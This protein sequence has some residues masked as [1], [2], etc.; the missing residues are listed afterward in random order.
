V[1]YPKRYL[2]PL[3]GS[4]EFSLKYR[5]WHI[6]ATL[7]TTILLRYIMAEKNVIP[8]LF[9]KYMITTFPYSFIF[10]LMVFGTVLW[11]VLMTVVEKLHWQMSS[12]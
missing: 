2:A 10:S 11:L 5:K 8:L 3:N 4:S 7:P 12:T 1:T 6:M 9:G